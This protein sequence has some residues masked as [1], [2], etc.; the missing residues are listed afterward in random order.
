MP[1]NPQSVYTII[2]ERDAAIQRI[3]DTGYIFVEFHGVIL[4]AGHFMTSYS[5]YR[6]RIIK[7]NRLGIEFAVEKEGGECVPFFLT[8]D[9]FISPKRS[10]AKDARDGW[11]KVE[12]D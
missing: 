6:R 7:M 4:R 11:L 2:Q 10:F 3:L 8:W 1:E 5:G 12:E 9:Q